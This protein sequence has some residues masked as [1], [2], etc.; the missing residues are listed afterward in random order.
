M[1]FPA[2]PAPGNQVNCNEISS[3]A[4]MFKPPSIWKRMFWNLT[5]LLFPAAC[6]VFSDTSYPVW[7]GN[8][9]PFEISVFAVFLN[10]LKLGAGSNQFG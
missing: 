7:N 1:W 8:V 4:T 3:R 5:S 10:R 2:L 6:P 9:Y